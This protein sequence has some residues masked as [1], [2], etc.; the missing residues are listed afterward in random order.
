MLSLAMYVLAWVIN[1]DHLSCF[2]NL[3]LVLAN[4]I[5]MR[6]SAGYT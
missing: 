4:V 2:D 6:D 1:L 5:A 3:I